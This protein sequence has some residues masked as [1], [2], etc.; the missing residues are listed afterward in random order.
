MNRDLRKVQYTP[1]ES[2]YKVYIIDEVIK[3]DPGGVQC[4]VE[5]L[6]ELP[7][8]LSCAGHHGTPKIPATIISRCQGLYHKLANG[9]STA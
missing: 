2:N 5:K 6:E 8:M 3:V 9:L 7:V 1:S 4:F